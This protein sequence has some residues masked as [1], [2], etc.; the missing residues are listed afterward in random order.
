[1]STTNTDF[2]YITIMPL[3]GGLTLGNYAATGN[4]PEA[5]IRFD[6]FSNENW[7][8]DY[9]PD[10]PAHSFPLL[11]S[12]D[13]YQMP[14]IDG[15]DFCSAVPL[16]SGLSM[17]NSSVGRGSEA[18]QN[19]WIYLTTELALK[20][21]RPKAL[22]GENAP[23]LFSGTGEG[24]AQ[25]LFDI[26]KKYNYSLT[27]YKTSTHL[28]GVPQ[29]RNRTFYIFWDSPYSP[30]L[31]W[32]N[33]QHTP[34]EEYLKEVPEWATLQDVYPAEELHTCG[35]FD[36][37]ITKLGTDW[38]NKITE[39]SVLKWVQKENL[40]DEIDQHL[41][42]LP[43]EKFPRVDKEIGLFERKKLKVDD[44][45]GYWDFT[46]TLRFDKV[47]AVISKNKMYVHPTEDRTLNIRELMHLMG[48][49]HD[50][51]VTHAMWHQITQNVPVRTSTDMTNEILK[52]LRGELPFSDARFVK[53]SN[54]S[55]TIDYIR[56]VV[57]IF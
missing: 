27:L 19:D 33:R 47:N 57:P 44:G 12:V 32:Y 14:E 21:Y 4:K 53:Q 8:Q 51:Q 50:F 26:A 18:P 13:D 43:I 10:V 30:I 24:V 15:V 52:F 49:P 20:N 31:N 37:L 39:T 17:L 16:C 1:M 55:Q 6:N 36:F 29:Q 28:H 38:R 9:W 41:K 5:I 40:W 54:I 22:I 56:E 3:I 35:Y 48:L 34:L 2:K 45:K 46:A 7:L 42:T 23:N 11:E 25:K